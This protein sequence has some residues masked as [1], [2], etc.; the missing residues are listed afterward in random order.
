VFNLVRRFGGREADLE[1]LTHDT[2]MAAWNSRAS[3]D[4]SRPLRPWLMGIA[5]R[6]VSDYLGRARHR[7]ELAAPEEAH[8]VPDPSRGPGEHAEAL[9]ARD[10][11][12]SALLQIAPERRAVF[13]MHEIEEL[14][15]SEVA[16]IIEVPEGTAWSRLRTARREFNAAVQ[17]LEQQGGR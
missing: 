3:F 9:Q 12:Q 4:V 15:I 2:F 16:R 17:S 7:V 10:L 8:T 5:F 14:P 13:V 1:D 11:V 6:V